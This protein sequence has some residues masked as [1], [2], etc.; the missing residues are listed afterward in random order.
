MARTAD[1]S[2]G[3]EI[4]RRPELTAGPPMGI[5]PAPIVIVS[6]G[7]AGSVPPWSIHSRIDESSSVDR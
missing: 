5:S 2:A 1:A 7:R 4:D 6:G 3:A